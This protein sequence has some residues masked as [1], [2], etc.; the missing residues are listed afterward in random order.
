M[1]NDYNSLDDK[2]KLAAYDKYSKILGKGQVD[3]FMTGNG[4]TLPGAAKPKPAASDSKFDLTAVGGKDKDKDNDKK[5]TK[6]KA[7]SASADNV[8]ALSGNTGSRSVIVTI[9]SL[10]ENLN[11]QTTNM[12]ST[13]TS[14]L[15]KAVEEVLVMAVRDS[16]LA[17]ASQ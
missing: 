5:K 9:K 13:S 7:P 6:A 4:M 17:L 16:E 10:V 2:G 3:A 15:R 11:I 12:A 8:H 1:L 14:A